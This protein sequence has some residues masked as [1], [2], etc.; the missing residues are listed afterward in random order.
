MNGNHIGF[1][2][3][4][5]WRMGVLDAYPDARSLEFETTPKGVFFRLTGEAHHAEYAAAWF[6]EYGYGWVKT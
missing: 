5:K 6:H 4:T 2:D 3:Q 1:T